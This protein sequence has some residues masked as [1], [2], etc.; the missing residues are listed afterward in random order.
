MPVVKSF[1]DM[2]MKAREDEAVRAVKPEHVLA[3]N[4][5]ADLPVAGTLGEGWS[6]AGDHMP[7]VQRHD[8]SLTATRKASDITAHAER[9]EDIPSWL[10]TGQTPEAIIEALG[11]GGQLRAWG[12][13][14][15][16]QIMTRPPGQADSQ[17]LPTASPDTEDDVRVRNAES[18]DK[19][20]Q[21]NGYHPGLF[22]NKSGTNMTA[23]QAAQ[24]ISDQLHARRAALLDPSA[25]WSALSTSGI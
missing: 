20:I 5:A 13:A 6:T 17:L 3:Q 2:L 15:S 18:R 25:W 14:P 4:Y 7:L 11:T 24:I 8:D 16:T 19:F 1:L 10:Y 23:N 21:K 12:D 22:Q 9:G